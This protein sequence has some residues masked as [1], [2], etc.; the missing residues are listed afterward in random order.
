MRVSFPVLLG[1]AWR[2]WRGDWEILTAV[3]GIF[4]FLPQL[5]VNMLIPAGPV[6][7]E[8]ADAVAGS[9]AMLTYQAK[10]LD[11]ASHYVGWLA[12]A[13][14]LA[15]FGQFALVALYL[16]RDRPAVGS[17][18]GVAARRF[19]L[20][21]LAGLI[22]ALP[23]LA[24]ATIVLLLPPLIFAILVIVFWISARTIALAP[25]LLAEG[26]V[27]ALGA[28]RRS[29]DLTRGNTLAL[30]AAVMT[31]V[32]AASILGWPFSALDFWMTTHAPNP[33]ARAIVDAM[34]ALVTALGSIAMAL[35]QV[36]VYRR[37]RTR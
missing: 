13:S 4:V 8:G 10:A 7:P 6:A 33:I 11:W 32:L 25:I 5:A 31:I 26:S 17:A 16:S 21:I 15:L 18:L 2:L 9:V 3:A 28:I 23:L 12:L 22:I 1:D 19:P 34:T 14:V 36:T 24:I 20:V 27:G 35:L 30:A 37:L 29:L